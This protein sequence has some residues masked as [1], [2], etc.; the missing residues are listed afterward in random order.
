MD[1]I[2]TNP[3]INCEVVDNEAVIELCGSSKELFGM[4]CSI[5]FHLAK[6]FELNVDSFACAI[7]AATINVSDSMT[8]EE[9]AEIDKKFKKKEITDENPVF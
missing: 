7:A 5:I 8:P 9:I 4:A 6:V 2:K 3:F 1:N